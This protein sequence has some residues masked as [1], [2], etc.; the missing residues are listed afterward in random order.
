MNEIEN[1][2]R[3]DDPVYL[4]DE[5]LGRVGYAI[6]VKSVFDEVMELSAFPFDDQCFDI[7][8]YWEDTEKYT[9][10]LAAHPK[11]Q[12]AWYGACCFH[13]SFLEDFAGLIVANLDPAGLNLSHV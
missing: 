10:R 1:K 4:M 3:V 8:V 6:T 13:D 5:K 2:K 12:N 7:R 11:E 9:W